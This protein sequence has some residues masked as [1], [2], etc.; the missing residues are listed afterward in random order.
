MVAVPQ[1]VPN[2]NNNNNER[3]PNRHEN[4]NEGRDENR[5]RR[6]RGSNRRATQYP[7]NSD[8]PYDSDDESESDNYNHHDLRPR[9][10]NQRNNAEIRS[11]R[12]NQDPISRDRKQMLNRRIKC[13]NPISNPTSE[14]I[15]TF[16]R[17][18]DIL[19]NV[20]ANDEEDEY[21]TEELKFK[22]TAVDHIPIRNITA[23]VYWNEL[24]ALLEREY[25][26]TNTE[27]ALEAKLRSL[28]QKHT[29]TTA[30]Y[31]ERARKLMN[32]Y[33]TFYGTQMTQ[34]LRKRINREITDQFVK[35]TLN[36]KVREAMRFRGASLDLADMI[37]YGIEQ[38]TLHR[39]TESDPEVICSY[40]QRRGHKSTQCHT[41]DRA[42]CMSNRAAGYQNDR[43]CV[44]CGLQGHTKLHCL[45]HPL[46]ARDA[47][48]GRVSG[49]KNGQSKIKRSI[50]QK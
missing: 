44:Q 33:E 13:I 30:E 16:V 34:H 41:K 47:S 14:N 25:K 36:T 11:P 21:C 3:P 43:T 19:M 10:I 26:E 23:C 12:Q 28:T 39:D 7:N 22:I 20:V 35:T 46:R 9:R 45:V 15:M 24:K 5:N 48:I 37:N 38:E 29:E 31:G 40:C 49:N 27:N 17:A 1:A 42:I 8:D 32:E 6:R 18:A 4:Q 2:P 50:Q